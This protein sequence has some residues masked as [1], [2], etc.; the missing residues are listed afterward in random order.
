MKLLGDFD[1]SAPTVIWDLDQ[2]LIDSSH[3]NTGDLAHWIEHSTVEHIMKDSLLP[4][5]SVYR[6][7]VASKIFNHI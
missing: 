2:T 1:H 5:V 7:M 6:S 3:R 4:M